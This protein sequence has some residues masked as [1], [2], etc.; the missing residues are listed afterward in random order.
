MSSGEK[1]VSYTYLRIGEDRIP[2]QITSQVIID[3]RE[4][5]RMYELTGR[6]LPRVYKSRDLKAM[7]EEIQDDI[8]ERI[9]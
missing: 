3:G 1:M 5:Y 6:R 9:I 4:S 8:L 2:I 7:I